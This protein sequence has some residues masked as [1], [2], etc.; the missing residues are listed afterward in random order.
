MESTETLERNS[1]VDLHALE[2]SLRH[3]RVL[4]SFVMSFLTG[5]A[6]IAAMFPL[7][8]VLYMLLEKGGA[9]LN[10]SVLTELPPPAMMPSGGVGN[11]IAGTILIVLMRFGVPGAVRFGDARAGRADNSRPHYN[12]IRQ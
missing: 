2:R 11:A 6:T 12:C 7:F 1:E 3:P 9:A 10:L 5:A 4:F 8:S